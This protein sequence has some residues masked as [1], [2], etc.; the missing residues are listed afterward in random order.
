[1]ICPLEGLFCC[2]C[3]PGNLPRLP[4]V[5]RKRL[6][7]L[8]IASVTV[9]VKEGRSGADI[10]VLWSGGACT[11]YWTGSPSSALRLRTDARVLEA[12]RDLATRMPD[13]QVAAALTN[14]GLLSRHGKPWT[15]GRVASMRQQ[16]RIPTACPTHTRGVVVRADGFVPAKVA[17]RQL[18]IT[19]G[20][21]RIWAHR[22][23]LACD[24]S[25]EAAKLWIRLDPGDVER[26]SGQADPAGMERVRD[27]ASRNASPTA[28][29]WER[30][31][32]G[33]FHAYRVQTGSRH[34]EWRLSPCSS[35]TVLPSTRTQ[36]FST[37][38]TAA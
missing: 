7:R 12:I 25:S 21:L 6:L 29:V 4:P 19:L 18:G 27:V 17:A 3:V 24:Q 16:H 31:R 11:T 10:L 37:A 5:D 28:S 1:V 34:W 8:A 32:K 35:G 33:E 9:T 30:V 36:S 20:A 15:R 23:V 2:T 13:H 26:L 38:R 14:Q 22:G